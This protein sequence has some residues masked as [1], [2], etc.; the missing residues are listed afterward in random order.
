MI[1]LTGVVI[2]AAMTGAQLVGWWLG[3]FVVGPLIYKVWH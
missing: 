1:D 3:L 2:V